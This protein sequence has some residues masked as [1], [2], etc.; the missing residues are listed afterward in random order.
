[1]LD[2]INSKKK[3]N[4]Q[5]QLIVINAG[6]LL[7][8]V[9][10]ENWILKCFCQYDNLLKQNT[11]LKGSYGFCRRIINEILLFLILIF[12]V[13]RATRNYLYGF[14]L[15]IYHDFVRWRANRPEYQINKDRQL[16]VCYF[17]IFVNKGLFQQNVN[18]VWPNHT[19]EVN[20]LLSGRNVTP[21]QKILW[22]RLIHLL[23]SFQSVVDNL[24]I[25]YL[26]LWCT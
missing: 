26:I 23:Q 21:F 3:F 20:F 1:M 17:Y 12:Y 10:E 25:F 7:K 15:R 16:S 13:V 19:F 4:K 14:Y 22:T 6:V 9:G 18:L 24:H 5:K 2:E 11:N 8:T